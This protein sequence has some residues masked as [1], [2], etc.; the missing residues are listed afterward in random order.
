MAIK[1]NNNIDFDDFA[2]KYKDYLSDSLKSIDSNT[3]YYHESKVKITKREINFDPE[4]ILDFG[5]GIGMITKFLYKHFPVCNLFA[6]D[7]SEKSLSYVKSQL[8]NINCLDN[9]NIETKFDLIF[10]SNVIHHVK[11]S[12]RNDFLTKIRSLLNNNGKVIIFEH[13]PYNPITLKI[14]SDCDFDVDAELIKK[15]NL[16]DL[17]SKNK[18]QVINSGYIHFFPSKLKIFFNLEKYMKW[19]FLG[20]QYFCIFK[21]D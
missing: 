10:V 11:S 12:D 15:N 9:L 19:F 13:N 17:C 1:R 4:A 20:A 7:N 5:C 2:E 6:Y 3:S 14:V 16:I 18:L 21:K 8:P